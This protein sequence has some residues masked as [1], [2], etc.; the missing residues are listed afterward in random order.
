[1]KKILVPVDGSQASEKAA[2]KA[3]EIARD[4]NSEITYLSVADVRG[5]YAYMGD[6][7][8]SVPINHSQIS[9]M[10]VENQ[11]KMLDAF[12]SIVDSKGINIEKKVAAGVPYEE[13]LKYAADN[14]ADLIVMSRRG[15]TKFKRFFVGSVTQRVISDAPCPVLVI[16]EDEEK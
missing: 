14:K 10:L 13:I 9:A 3:I 1:M 11:T 6:G 4:Y 12:A 8:V 7:V 5:K 2:M 15:F 16:N